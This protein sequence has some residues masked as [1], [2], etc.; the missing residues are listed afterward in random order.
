M[1]TEKRTVDAEKSYLLEAPRHTAPLICRSAYSA[2]AFLFPSVLTHSLYGNMIHM[3]ITERI[4][5][6]SC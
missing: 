6:P 5:L 3:L 1:G 2:F 4:C